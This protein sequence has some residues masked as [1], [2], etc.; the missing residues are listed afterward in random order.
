MSTP[1]PGS[2]PP[3]S[4][5]SGMTLLVELPGVVAQEVFLQHG[6]TIGRA[7]SNAICINHSEV[8]HIHA[9]LLKEPDGS[10]CLRGE[11]GATIEVIEPK[12]GRTGEVKVEPGLLIRL[13]DATIRCQETAGAAT[14]EPTSDDYWVE[15]AGGERFREECDG[16]SGWLPEKVGPYKI[17]KYVAR[18]GMGIVLRG[19]HEETG[20]IAAV[21]LPTPD[22]NT[23]EK[24]LNRFEQE[25]K[26]LKALVHP[27]LVRLQ[28]SGKEGDLHWLAMDWVKGQSLAAKLS[29][30]KESGEK[31][32]LEEI[33]LIL[34][35]TLQALA[36]LKDQGVIHRDLKPGN[37]LMGLDRSVKLA[38]FGLA[39]Q[40]TG[41]QGPAITMTGVYAGTFD[42]MSPEHREGMELTPAADVYALGV[43][44]HEMLTHKKP[45]P[46][47]KVQQHR[48]DCPENWIETIELCLDPDPEDRPDI[49]IISGLLGGSIESA[50]PNSIFSGTISPQPTDKKSGEAVGLLSAVGADL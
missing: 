1:S 5:S 30:L 15:A 10:F 33:K 43:I 25:S 29:E 35:Q 26:T 4:S 50:Q 19:V 48:R 36:Y 27:N 24:W 20:E 14:A 23:N 22:L 49:S 2:R 45:G 47:L 39:K 3:S 41:E 32:S 12:A 28:D 44:W 6:L 13:G 11:S 16:F 21:K 40:M 18:G 42:Y 38:D 17:T 37:L 9:R 7:T 34:Q 31:L 8:D 46:R